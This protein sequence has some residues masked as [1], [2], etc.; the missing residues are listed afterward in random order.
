MPVTFKALDSNS[1]FVGLIPHG[2][3]SYFDTD[4]KIVRTGTFSK[5]KLHGSNNILIEYTDTTFIYYYGDFIENK[6]HGNIILYEFNGNGTNTLELNG[7]I[8]VQKKVCTYIDGI[9]DEI[10]LDT[11]TTVN[12]NIKIINMNNNIFLQGFDINEI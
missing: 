9:L 1:K 8:L 10:I 11:P 3:C 12:I 6:Q 7:N 4:N 2:R 5:N